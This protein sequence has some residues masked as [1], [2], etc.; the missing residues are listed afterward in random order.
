MN[1][2]SCEY[3]SCAGCIDPA[4]CNYDDTATL[5]DGSCDYSCVGCL[6]PH[7]LN[8][9]ADCTIDDPE[10]CISCPGIQYQFTIFDSFG[11]GICCSY[12]EGSYSVSLDGEVMLSGGDFLSSE[13][14]SFCAEDSTSCV[15]VSLVPD[16]YPGETTWELV[17]AVTCLLY[18][19]DA[20]DD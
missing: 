13:S 17:N 12:G 19:S 16:N 15:V 8:Y 3:L 5:D 14:G 4:S 11:D 9:C 10:S 7:A 2:G 18:T 1:D 20:A 6:D